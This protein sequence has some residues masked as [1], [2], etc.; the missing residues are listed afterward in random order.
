MERAARLVSIDR[1]LDPRDFAMVCFGGAAPAHGCRLARALGVR[2]VVVPPAAGVGAALG[3][4][5]ADESFELARTAIVRLDEPTASERAGEIF[6][7]LES[8]ARA[9][10]G[11]AWGEGELAALRTVGLR[12][13]GQGFELEVGVDGATRDLDRLAEAFHAQYERTYGYREDLPVEAVTW[14]LT[15]LRRRAPAARRNGEAPA[16]AVAPMA[17]AGTRPAY[18]PERG[19][20][21][22]PVLAR[23]ALAAGD[24]AEGPCLVEEAHTTTVVLPGDVLAVDEHGALVVDVEAADA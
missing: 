21:D 1:G 17:R 15:L 10:V 14:F 19:M 5:E 18:F 6:A 22:V 9:T 4:L 23:S 2:R 12:F 16:R 11:D 8:E 20:V 3:L 13:A 7:G 24:R